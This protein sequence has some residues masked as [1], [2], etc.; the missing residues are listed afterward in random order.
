MRRVGLTVDACAHAIAHLDLA[1]IS[2]ERAELLLGEFLITDEER[3]RIA[4]RLALGEKLA[5]ID[6]FVFKV[7]VPFAY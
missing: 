6:E 5:E 3:A 2:P 4:A 7:R 1:S